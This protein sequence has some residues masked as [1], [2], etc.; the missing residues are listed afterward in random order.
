MVVRGPTGDPVVI[1]NAP[2][3]SDGT[4]MPT[5]Y[6]LVG[7]TEKRAV[8]RL[9]AAGGVRRAETEVPA[10]AVEAAHRTYRAER[11]DALP[12]DWTGARPSGGVAGTRQGVKCLHAHYAWY[13]AGGPDPVGRWVARQLSGPSRP[14][15][16]IDC[17]TNS[18]RLLVAEP[19]GP[20]F[21][22]LNR[23][24]RL[25]QG[26]DRTR[27]LA[28]GAI[29]RT[30]D[31][32][33]G[34][35]EV[36]DRFSVTAVRMTATSAARD[37]ANREEF[38]G[39]AAEIIGAAPELLDGEE[40]GRLSFAGATA[41]LDAAS[42]PW[43]VV[44]VGGGSTELVFGPGPGGGPTAVRSLDMGCVRL[45]E[46][47]LGSDPPGPEQLAEARAFARGL[48]DRAVADQPAFL[49]A[50]TLVGLAGTVACL[51]AV[52]QEISGYQREKVH[53]Y[54]LTAASV[55]RILERLAVMTSRQRLGVPGVE[56]E[57]ADVILGG[58]IVVSE[59]LQRFGFEECLT[60]E[61][62]ILDG[63]ILSTVR[64]V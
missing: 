45:T 2:L 55:E 8:D 42:G 52:D 60:S 1:R 16:A 46:R 10:E 43:L 21:E 41:E 14:A 11:D 53:H 23:I 37:A 6:W 22:R 29:G 24:T 4:P 54:R 13:L 28:P 33:R 19:G 61:A 59:V 26:V 50:R 17:G 32:L 27:R 15:A 20:T 3:L 35:R 30:L 18:T 56:A 63:L 36:M 31:V 48:L 34:Y 9:E 38:F 39:P 7:P 64:T 57:R 51:A 47:F 62:D 12:P 58:T 25:G 5:R 49:G 40:E 44:D